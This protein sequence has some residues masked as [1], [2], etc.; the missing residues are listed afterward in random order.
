MSLPAHPNTVETNKN[1]VTPEATAPHDTF[2]VATSPTLSPAVAQDTRS[3]LA[4]MALA[5]FTIP[6]GLA[7]AYRGHGWT[8]FWVYIG[9]NIIMI[10]PILGQIVGIITI[11]VLYLLGVI[12]VF[13]FRNATTDAFGAPLAMT[14]TDK[15]WGHGIFVFFVV[16]LSLIALLVLA[17]LAFGA[18]SLPQVIESL[19]TM[20]QVNSDPQ[21][22]QQY[23]EPESL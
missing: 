2:A 6:S 17:A 10:I 20:Q 8:R 7:R 21:L 1:E 19:N 18:T 14:P 4:V 13:K 5:V 15:K 16:M 9:A 23:F 3:Y 22:Q 12:D 11:F